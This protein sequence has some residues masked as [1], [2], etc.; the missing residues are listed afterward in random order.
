[1]NFG[2]IGYGIIGQTHTQVIESLPGARLT[3]IA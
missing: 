2:I 3:A 1:M